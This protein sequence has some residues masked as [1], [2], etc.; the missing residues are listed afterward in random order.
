[1]EDEEHVAVDASV[2][3][4]HFSLY[5][6]E[7]DSL[8]LSL[9]GDYRTSHVA[10]INCDNN[11][12]TETLLG[13]ES[14]RLELPRGSSAELPLKAV[15]HFGGDYRSASDPEA[16]VDLLNVEAEGRINLYR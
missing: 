5:C 9:G 12:K 6:V 8:N 7:A 15:W 13:T 2:Y 16:R 10:A 3:V 1:M 11:A 4:E 14:F